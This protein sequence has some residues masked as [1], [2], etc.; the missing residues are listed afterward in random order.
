C[1]CA[2]MSQSL[3]AQEF[4]TRVI[5]T[6]TSGKTIMLDR[7]AWEEIKLNDFAVIIR[8]V[9]KTLKNNKVVRELRPIAKLRSVKLFDTRSVWVVLEKIENVDLETG[10][11]IFLITE[12]ELLRGKKELG[13]KRTSLVSHKESVK[14]FTE[15]QLKRDNLDLAKKD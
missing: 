2:L 9:P 12:S 14:E 13:L 4:V 8:E 1:I 3:L 11:K 15:A 6:S 7:G 5:Q 10:T